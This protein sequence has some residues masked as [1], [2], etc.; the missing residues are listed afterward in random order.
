MP[1]RHNDVLQ[2]RVVL[3]AEHVEVTADTTNK[4]WKLTR[5]LRVDAVRYINPTGLVAD[6]THFFELKL[7][8]GASTVIA[9]WSTETGEEGTIAADTFVDFTMGAAADQVIPAGTVISLFLDEDA[10]AT[11]TL[12]AGRIQIEGRYL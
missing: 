6:A 12:P 2:E 5:D 8:Q 9:S 4:L 1:R 10:G 3:D 7:I 11:A